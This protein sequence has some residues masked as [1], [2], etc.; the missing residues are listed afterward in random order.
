MRH[1]KDRRIALATHLWLPTHYLCVT[2]EQ[3][4]CSCR[5]RVTKVAYECLRK[6][7][8][9]EQISWDVTVEEMWLF[10]KAFNYYQAVLEEP[11]TDNQSHAEL[12]DVEMHKVPKSRAKSRGSR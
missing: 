1:S 4:T 12:D 7:S 5:D 9:A 2:G 10:A 6:A 11:L 3:K 8:V